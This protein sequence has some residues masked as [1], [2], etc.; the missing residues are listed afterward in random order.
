MNKTYVLVKNEDSEKINKFKKS[1]L[2]TDIGVKSENFTSII[3][4][5]TFIAVGTLLL[6]YYSWRI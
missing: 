3:L 6:M 4:L 1:L 5:S 2:G